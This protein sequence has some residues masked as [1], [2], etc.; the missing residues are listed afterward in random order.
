MEDQVKVILTFNVLRRLDYVLEPTKTDVL[1]KKT[2][3]GLQQ[4]GLAQTPITFQ[5]TLLP[6]AQATKL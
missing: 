3:P 2:P 1:D 5:T 6:G 4:L